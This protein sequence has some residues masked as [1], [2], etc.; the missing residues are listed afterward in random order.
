MT[1]AMTTKATMT[2]AMMIRNLGSVTMP[3][4]MPVMMRSRNMR[5]RASQA[6]VSIALAILLLAVAVSP[7]LAQQMIYIPIVAAPDQQGGGDDD[8]TSDCLL[9]EFEATLAQ[10]IVSHPDQR[11]VNP[12]CHPLLAQAARAKA[13][14]MAL[15]GYFS[16]TNPDG[17]GP[18]D[19]VRQTG[20]PLPDW[21]G[22]GSVNNIES[23][24]GGYTTPE[25]AWTAWQ[26]SSGHR[27]H[28]LGT[29]S[30]YAG[31]TAYGLGY[32]YNEGSPLEHYWVFL[33]AP[34]PEAAQ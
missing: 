30:F 34:L 4:T 15:R 5:R 7:A 23:I 10:A 17:I 19:L 20:Y 26:N 12:V 32:Y 11:R 27:T 24:A 29:D 6:W 2:K 28:L 14:D 16:H 31:Q 9:N 33:S 13:R 3:V 25:L 21:Y 1:K 8:S 22:S 18:N